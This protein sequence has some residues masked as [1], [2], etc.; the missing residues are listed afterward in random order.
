MLVL[1][2]NEET[3]LTILEVLLYDPLYSWTI[4]PAEAYS[5]QKDDDSEGSLKF[6][7]EGNVFYYYSKNIYSLIHIQKYKVFKKNVTAMETIHSCF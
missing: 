7:E 4:T 6:S 5:R 1:R 2:Q 3:I